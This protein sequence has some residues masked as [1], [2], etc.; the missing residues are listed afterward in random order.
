MM[1]HILLDLTCVVVCR[2]S[3]TDDPMYVMAENMMQRHLCCTAPDTLACFPFV[4]EDPFILRS[5]PHV[6][7]VGNQAS[8]AEDSVKDGDKTIKLVSI[9]S[10]SKTGTIVLLDLQTLQCKTVS[11]DVTF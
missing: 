11:F 1:L 5:S 7:F 9:P 6:Y 8:F 3:N 10:F 4:E 2:Y